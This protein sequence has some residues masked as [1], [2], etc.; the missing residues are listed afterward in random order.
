V[1]LH[2]AFILSKTM[3]SDSDLLFLD[4]SSASSASLTSTVA[5]PDTF[6]D[7]FEEPDLHWLSDDQ[8]QEMREKT[9][10]GNVKVLLALTL[11]NLG[12]IY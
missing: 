6:E 2:R 1:Q 5:E 4:T 10:E 7:F 3:E 9:Q 11:K 8:V 12:S